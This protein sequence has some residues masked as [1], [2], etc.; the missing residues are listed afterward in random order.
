[1]KKYIEHFKN[2]CMWCTLL[3]LSVYIVSSGLELAIKSLRII[4]C[5]PLRG[6]GYLAVGAFFV[7]GLFQL[8]DTYKN[9]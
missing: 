6:L 8:I 5:E 4:I 9:A 3:V 1:M 2:I 7:V